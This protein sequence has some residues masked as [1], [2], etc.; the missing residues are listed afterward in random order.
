MKKIFF[1]LCL[2]ST[3]SFCQILSDTIKVK[4]SW[5]G[6]CMPYSIYTGPGLTADRVS[7][8]IEFGRSFGVIDAGL[9]YGRI[10]LRP[11]S[12]Q[13]L[14]GKVTMDA[15]QYGIFSNEFSIGA[16]KVFNSRMPIMLE[17]STTIMAQVAKSWGVGVVTGYY[18]L[19]GT[20]Y[21][22]NKNYFGIFIRYGLLRNDGGILLNRKIRIHHHH[23]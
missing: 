15:C 17:V 20:V 11:D 23:L 10:S 21:G 6:R 16:G 9:V 3:N 7:Q 1:I 2:I 13:Y 12:T 19:S 5:Y 4:S 14:E 8:N 22:T 18:D